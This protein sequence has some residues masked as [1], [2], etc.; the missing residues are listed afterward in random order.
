[1]DPYQFEA[2]L[3]GVDL[4]NQ[5]E[6]LDGQEMLDRIVQ[7]PKTTV[8]PYP[9]RTPEVVSG[10]GG[11]GSAGSGGSG[12]SGSTTTSPPEDTTLVP[13]DKTLKDLADEH[14]AL[15]GIMSTMLNV[16]GVRGI[17]PASETLLRLPLSILASKLLEGD[18]KLNAKKWDAVA[19]VY[20]EQEASPKTIRELQ[21]YVLAWVGATNTSGTEGSKYFDPDTN[22]LRYPEQG[23]GFGNNEHAIFPRN[24]KQFYFLLSII[25][26]DECVETSAR[27]IPQG[28]QA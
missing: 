16:D 9:T 20:P 7:G 18:D 19:Q 24:K 22:S 2:L 28:P 15:Q 13:G 26:S 1:M 21:N 14:M 4:S 11:S 17:K 3:G 27:G 25:R 5:Q 8:A 10:G 12:G 6:F 23:K